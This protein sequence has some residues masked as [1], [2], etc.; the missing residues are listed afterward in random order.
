MEAA[1]YL[2]HV[3]QYAQKNH[4]LRNTLSGILKQG[5]YAAAGAGIGGAAG[6]PLGALIGTLAA[7]IIG[8]S[9]TDDYESILSLLRDLTPE[10]KNNLANEVKS[11]VG[12]S[13]LSDFEEWFKNFNHQEML[14]KLFSAFAMHQ[15][16]SK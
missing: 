12:S 16:S 11:M 2:H 1:S 5:G 9:E 15:L 3:L 4:N 7:A 13:T 14:F 10:E 8:Y 6:G